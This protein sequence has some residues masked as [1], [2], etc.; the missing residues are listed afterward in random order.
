MGRRHNRGLYI[1]SDNDLIDNI[2]FLGNFIF[3]SLLWEGS[4]PPKVEMFIWILL[5]SRVYTRAFLAHRHLLHPSQAIYPFCEHEKEH[6]PHLFLHCYH[7]WRLWK[8][9]LRWFD[10]FN[11][12]L[13]TID[14]VI[15]QWS[16]MVKGK[17]QLILHRLAL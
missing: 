15:W 7:M 8:W 1:K 16:D 10:S 12:M 13:N 17:F 6:A 5:Q 3:T 14:Q 4:A 9:F 2:L 11:C